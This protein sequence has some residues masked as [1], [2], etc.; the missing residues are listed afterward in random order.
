MSGAVG[1]LHHPGLHVGFPFLQIADAIAAQDQRLGILEQTFEKRKF[2]GADGHGLLLNISVRQASLEG[3]EEADQPHGFV[4]GGK[5]AGNFIS[6]ESAKTM[7]RDKIGT[8][9]LPL[10]NLEDI[11]ARHG[12]D[13]V[14]G[15][16]S[17]Q[18]ARLDGVDG[19]VAGEMPRQMFV[20]E[21]GP[22]DIVDEKERRVRSARANGNERVGGSAFLR[23]IGFAGF[24]N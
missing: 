22:A 8:L 17:A 7:A 18:A 1:R 14:I 11:V 2:A 9:G 5:Q 12:F 6:D 24:A 10:A 19:L 23:G 20:A 4:L 3:V 21:D 15:G 16:Q 13:A